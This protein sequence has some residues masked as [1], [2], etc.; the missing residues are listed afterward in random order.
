MEGLHGHANAAEARL[1]CL[2]STSSSSPASVASVSPASLFASQP[3]VEVSP[4]RPLHIASVSQDVVVKLALPKGR[5]EQGKYCLFVTFCVIQ[6][7][8][9][10]QESSSY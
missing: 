8:R 3:E 1:S 9:G 4:E 10:M 7:T 6:L 5:M 2:S